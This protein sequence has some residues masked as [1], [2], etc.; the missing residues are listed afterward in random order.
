MH[1]CMQA[2]VLYCWF[3]ST[4]IKAGQ[5]GWMDG[6]AARFLAGFL[7]GIFVPLS[8]TNVAADFCAFRN[9][10][11]CVATFHL[12]SFGGFNG[13]LRKVLICKC[14]QT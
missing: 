4:C 6:W 5:D 7:G 10:L 14:Y 8:L 11:H 9:L 1:T 13:F 3:Q 12:S 2:C